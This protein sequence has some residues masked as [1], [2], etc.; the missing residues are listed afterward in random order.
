MESIKLLSARI[1]RQSLKISITD[2]RIA[3]APALSGSVGVAKVYTMI[4]LEEANSA[5]QFSAVGERRALRKERKARVI[6]Y[7]ELFM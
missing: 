2:S 6:W 5:Q 1:P 4:I 7:L 3:H